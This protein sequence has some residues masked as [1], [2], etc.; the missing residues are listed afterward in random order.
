M[1]INPHVKAIMVTGYSRESLSG[2][3]KDD[4]VQGFLQKPFR[5]QELSELI[6]TTMQ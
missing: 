3:L 1:R 4:Y 2:V 5:M 6:A